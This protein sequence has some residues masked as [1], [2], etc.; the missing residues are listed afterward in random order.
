MKLSVK[1]LIAIA[2]VTIVSFPVL[3]LIVL[4]ATGNARVEFGR[5]KEDV[6]RVDDL[7]VIHLTSRRD[8]LIAAHSEAYRAN[9]TQEEKLKERE[10]LLNERENRV[11]MLEQELEQQKLAI[12]QERKAL[13]DAVQKSDEAAEKKSRQVAKIYGTMRP[14]EAAQILEKMNDEEVARILKGIGDE[15]QKG[16]IMEA[17]SDEKAIRVSRIIGASAAGKKSQ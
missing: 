12:I 2:A 5:K 16:K 7:R 14:S 3:Y 11:K 15:R 4:F 9:L 1:D 13:E 6:K 10:R 17:L 8:S